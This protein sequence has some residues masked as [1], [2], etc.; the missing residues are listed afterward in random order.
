M[1]LLDDLQ[2]RRWDLTRLGWRMADLITAAVCSSATADE[3]TP[4]RMDWRYGHQRRRGDEGDRPR[5]RGDS[6]AGS[7]R[8]IRSNGPICAW[9]PPVGGVASRVSRQSC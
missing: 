2:R 9:T 1:A 8:I 3:Q 4:R 5:S 7:A 6:F